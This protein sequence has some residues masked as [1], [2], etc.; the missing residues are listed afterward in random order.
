[1]KL[2]VDQNLSS[3]LVR[4]L[5]AEYPGSSHVVDLGF[6]GRPDREIWDSARSGNW[7]LVS[8][9]D[10]FQQLGFRFGHPPEIVR[11]RIGNAG[12]DRITDLLRESSARIATFVE[13][14]EAAVLIL[15]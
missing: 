3:R 2:L 11:L 1:M 7:V 8:K 15:S 14:P 5:S 12:T 13:D 6:S 10:D 9:D 4:M